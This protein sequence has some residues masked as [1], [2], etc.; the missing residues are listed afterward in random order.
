MNFFPTDGGDSTASNAA[1][2][3]ADGGDGDTTAGGGGGAWSFGGLL[4]TIATKSE[5]F[6]ETYRRDLEEFGAGLK[7]E[8][9]VFAGA[10]K[11]LPTSLEAGASAA[12]TGLESVGQAI[13]DLGSSVWRGTA[14]I[15][16]HGKGAL[17]AAASDDDDGGP[18]SDSQKNGV[19]GFD[20]AVRYSRFD[21]LVYAIQSDPATYCDEPE[22]GE[23][24]DRWRKTVHLEEKGEE[25]GT[26]AG[27]EGAM[28]GVYNK[29][30]PSVVDHETF[31]LRYFYKVYKLKQAEDARANLVKRAISGD[32][33]ED[34][35]WEVEDDEDEQQQVVN[36]GVVGDHTDLGGAE[37]V[38][39][40]MED[41]A[42][43]SINVGGVTGSLGE[44][45]VQAV[46][47]DAKSGGKQVHE[48]EDLGWDEIEDVG[49]G[50]EK[51]GSG[52]SGSPSKEELR[53]RLS[54][55]EDDEDLSWD[56]EDD[57]PL[58]P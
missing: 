20:P 34:L 53:R 4:K 35:S 2:A 41:D 29:L 44:N 30:V 50:D 22:D 45:E 12:Q 23:E 49:S 13:D 52:C 1:A 39:A 7:K 15:I 32:D 21:A 9:A 11:D 57:E 19:F 14:D 51:K 40:T 37:E 56:I 16:S 27:F 54:V 33:E 46:A 10:I 17:L 58:K 28:E 24:F 47:L 38:V 42:E 6:V 5:T 25:I 55:A 3:P 8:T 43:K 26:L 31:W 48:E 36:E 18:A